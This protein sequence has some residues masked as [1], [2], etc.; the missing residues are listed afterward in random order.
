MGEPLTLGVLE[1]I[2]N[3]LARRHLDAYTE[4]LQEASSLPGLRAKEVNDALWGTIAL[5]PIEVALL[6]SPLLQRLRFVRQLGAVHWVYPGAVHTRFEHTLGTLFQVQRLIGALNSFERAASRDGSTLLEDKEVQLLRLC[7]LLRH[8]GHVAFSQVSENA[9]E[10]MPVLATLSTALTKQLRWEFPGEDASL[11][12]VIAYYIVRSPAMRRFLRVG[13]AR[14]SPKLSFDPDQQKSLDMIVE[15]VSCALIGRKI[16]D[17]VP[18]LHELISGPYDGAKLDSLVRDAKFAGIPTVLDIQRLMQKLV[19][20]RLT[21]RELPTGIA[22]IVQREEHE[23]VWLFGVKAAAASA[24]DELQLSNVLASTKIYHHPKVVAVEQMIRSFVDT[25]FSIASPEV[26]LPFLYTHGDDALLGMTGDDIA[27]A[28]GLAEAEADSVRTQRL[29]DAQKVLRELRERRLWVRAFQLSGPD[30]SL[31]GDHQ[32]S[33][34][35]TR[36]RDDFG[37]V[38]R[39]R[40]LMSKVRDGVH[41]LLSGGTEPPPSRVSLDS[42]ILMRTLKSISGETQIGRALLMQEVKR[43]Y[44]LSQ[45][46]LARGNWVE[47]YMSGQPKGY[48]FCPTFLA[49]AVFVAIERVARIEYQASLPATAAEASKRDRKSL[50]EFKRGLKEQLWSGVPHDI[51]PIPPRLDQAD[52]YGAVNRFDVHRAAYQEPASSPTID[53]FPIAQ[54]QRTLQWLRQFENPAS[55]E[56]AMHLLDHVRVLDR[57]DTT[58]ALQSIL[59]SHPQFRGSWVVPFGNIKDSGVFQAYFSADLGREEIARQASLAEYVEHGNGAPLIFIDDFIGSGSQ[60]TDILAA[61]FERNDLRK[62]LGEQRDSL[63]ADARERLKAVPI[64]FL[65]VAGWSDGVTKLQ[66]ICT[67]LGLDATV[68]CYVPENELPFAGPILLKRFGLDE[69]A[70]FLA[71]CRVIGRELI[72]SE[73]RAQPLSNSVVEDRALGYGGRGMLLAS[74]ANVPSQTMTA[75]WMDGTVDGVPWWPLLRRRKKA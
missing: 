5:T 36:L 64:A 49:D 13:I 43:P 59:E 44:P 40:D 14:L 19:V 68:N 75:I 28:L 12:E 6:D 22:G 34:G 51:R 3:A 52:R 46:M 21:A 50:L 25:I 56:C 17:R 15:K 54:S 20:E 24:L 57:N 16:D 67:T 7:A 38:Q 29:E 18:L 45:L 73:Q 4:R 1:A 8:T 58:A 11:S 55:I 62:P 65:F 60:A 30:A 69:V 32:E 23:P 53:S 66:E 31:G 42:L 71:R 27:R 63:H 2:A 72:R 41:A 47:L 10:E 35:L 37:H 33:V 9:M 48:I 39:R 26:A 70:Q 74:F 61:W